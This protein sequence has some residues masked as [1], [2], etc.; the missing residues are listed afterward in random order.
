[1]YYAIYQL[2]GSFITLLCFPPLLIYWL[3]TGKYRK[4][5]WQRF[6]FHQIVLPSPVGE[7]VWLHASSVGEVQAAR[8]LLPELKKAWPDADYIL[9]TMTEQ[10]RQTARKQLGEEMYCMY[11]PVDI[12]WI[13]RR[14]MNHLRPTIYICL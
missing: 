10:G 2:A 13:V 9:S 11:A 12:R 14:V 4:E 3:I 7:R 6:G 8:A 5:V 1:M